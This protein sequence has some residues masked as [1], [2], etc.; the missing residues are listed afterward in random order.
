MNRLGQV[1]LLGVLVVTFAAGCGPKYR[2]VYSSGFSFAKYDFMV[3]AKPEAGSTSIPLLGMDI[4]FGNLMSQHNMKIIGDKEFNRLPETDQTRTLIARLALI[5][6][7]ELNKITVVFD[8]A[9]SGRTVAS[10]SQDAKGDMLDEDERTRA[11]KSLTN[12]V[13]QAIQKDKGLTIASGT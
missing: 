8:D 9:V 3:I 12:V 4:E 13:I 6:S 11:L 7:A 2:L 5:A 1:L 10:I